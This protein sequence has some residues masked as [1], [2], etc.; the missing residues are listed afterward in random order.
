MLGNPNGF[1][2]FLQLDV[3]VTDGGGLT[4]RQTVT[5][6]VNRNLNTPVLTFPRDYTISILDTQ[7]PTVPFLSVLGT[8]GDQVQIWLL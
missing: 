7:A 8:D 2:P 5:V 6:P 1:L 3:L 4:D